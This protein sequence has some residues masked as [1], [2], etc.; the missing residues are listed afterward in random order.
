MSI[1]DYFNPVD[2]NA[3]TGGINPLG[4]YSLMNSVDTNLSSALEKQQPGTTVAIIGVPEFN[5]NREVE[6][7]SSPDTIRKYFYRL[8]SIDDR[9]RLTDP[10]NLKASESHKG[11]LLAIRDVVEYFHQLGV[12][13]VL[14]GGSQELTAGIAEAF[15]D[16]RFL[17]LSVVDALF[18]IK[19]GNEPFSSANYLSHLFR[20]QPQL[21][22]F[23]LIAYQQHLTS[24][25][26]LDTTREF[27]SHLRLGELRDNM[28]Q[29]E[30]LLRNSNILSFDMGAIKHHDAPGT[31]QKNPNG[32]R[33]EEA[34]QLAYYAGL[35]SRLHAF[36]LFEMTASKKDHLTPALAAEIAWYFLKGVSLRNPAPVK[37]AFKVEVEGIDQPILFLHDRQLNQWWFELRSLSGEVIEIACSEK[38]YRQAA[39]NEIPDRWVMFLQKLDKLPK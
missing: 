32:L 10:G 33:G 27:G 39:A 7:G 12:V 9:L 22:Q 6:G 18:D 3:V 38:E 13:V 14:L 16:E 34:C 11:T 21:F 29:A 28:E 35:T 1:S 25:Y 15:R 24:R 19:K 30:L 26:L 20:N 2:L 23:S 31:T 5:G 36:G 8:A 17:W 4:K 37:T